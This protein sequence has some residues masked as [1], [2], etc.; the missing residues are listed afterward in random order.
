MLEQL[1]ETWQALG[2]RRQASLAA[3]AVLI[4]GGLIAVGSWAIRPSWAVLYAELSAQDAQAVVEQLREQGVSYRLSQGGTAVL[5]PQEKLYE[6]RIDLAGRGLLAGSTVGFELFDRT[7]LS[8]SDLQNSV[9]LQRALQGELERSICALA[10]I[11]SAR[12]HLALPEERL[13]SDQQEPPSASVVVNLG[14]SRLG[15]AQVGAITQLVAS[16]VPG[17]D[18]DAVTVVDTTGAMLTGGLDGMGGMQTLAQLE[19]TRAWEERLRGHLQSMLDSVLGANRSVVRVQASLDFQ[20]QAI[21]RET[22]EP[23]D[24][25]GVVRREEITSEQ[26]DGEGGT[27][28][29][30]SA[31]LDGAA[32]PARAGSGGGNYEHRSETREYDYTRMHEEVSSPPG[33]LQRLAVAVVVDEGLNGDIVGQVRGLVEAAAGIDSGRGDQVTVEMMAIDA[34]KVA[35]EQTK[36][37]EAAEAERTRAESMSRGV[38]YGTIIVMLAMIGAAMLMM[39][40]KLGAAAPARTSAPVEPEDAEALA[41]ALEEAPADDGDLEFAPMSVEQLQAQTGGMEEPGGAQPS[42]DRIVSR[43]SDLGSRSPEDF[44]RH[45]S[46]WLREGAPADAAASGAAGDDDN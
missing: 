44:A 13:F 12:V 24:G 18:S 11:A 8:T 35:E 22:L 1:T 19:A 7:S 46:G 3:L 28:V 4:V 32:D 41:E 27:Q 33:S 30:G 9:N 39:T 25:Q 10:E 45:L 37:A 26:Y 6:L 36:L 23:A 5:V 31:G 40:R 34:V 29:G 42:P 2:R 21:T 38:R 43:L 15:S 20:S 14:N 17:L 16:A